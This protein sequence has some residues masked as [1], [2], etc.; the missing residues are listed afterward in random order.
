MRNRIVHGYFEIRLDVIWRAATV[1]LPALKRAVESLR[2]AH[3][4]PD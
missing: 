4:S 1:E 3:K 2:A